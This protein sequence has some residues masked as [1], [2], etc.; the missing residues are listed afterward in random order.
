MIKHQSVC[1]WPVSNA[2][3]VSVCWCSCSLFARG[4]RY[5]LWYAVRW[6]ATSDRRAKHREEHQNKGGHLLGKCVALVTLVYIHGRAFHQHVFPS[7]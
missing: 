2:V 3:Q 1:M 6:T 5:W 7:V 4:F